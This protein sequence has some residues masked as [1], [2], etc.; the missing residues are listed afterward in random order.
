MSPEAVLAV[1]VIWVPAGIEVSAQETTCRTEP[2]IAL[3]MAPFNVGMTAWVLDAEPEIANV[4]A[5]RIS[6]TSASMIVF[7][8]TSVSWV[9]VV[10]EAIVLVVIP[11][12]LL[13]TVA[14]KLA[15]ARV[16]TPRGALT[17]QLFAT[18][19]L[20]VVKFWFLKS[21]EPSVL[22]IGLIAIVCSLFGLVAFYHCGSMPPMK[23]LA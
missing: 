1:M 12:G 10:A 8:P 7:G 14:P 20:E 13:R 9:D 22:Y 2:I 4:T 5:S 17:R 11:I 18:A 16:I 23:G 3:A 6:V 19:M 15:P 21:L